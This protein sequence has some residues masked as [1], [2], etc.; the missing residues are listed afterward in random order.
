MGFCLEILGDIEFETDG[1]GAITSISEANPNY[2]TTVLSQLYYVVVT[3]STVGYGDITPQTTLHKVF[4]IVMIVSGVAFFSLEV[5]AIVAL[6][7][8]STPAGGSTAARDFETRTSSC[9]A[10]P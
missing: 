8:R 10:A 2:D 7:T 1:A 5:S 9:W 4:A 3:L 6:K